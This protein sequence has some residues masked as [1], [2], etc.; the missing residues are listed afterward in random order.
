MGPR[1]RG[2]VLVGWERMV[3]TLI[4]QVSGGGD[5]GHDR[6]APNVF[7]GIDVVGDEPATQLASAQPASRHLYRRYAEPGH[8]GDVGR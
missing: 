2:H 4:R 3:S 7:H 8:A 5:N 6:R 1:R